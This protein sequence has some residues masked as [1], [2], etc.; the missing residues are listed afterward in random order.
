MAFEAKEAA[1][2]SKVELTYAA[3]NNDENAANEDLQ[4]A[5]ALT[6][7]SVVLNIAEASLSVDINSE[8]FTGNATVAY[9]DDYTFS[10]AENGEYYNYTNI[11]ANM[12]GTEVDVLDN[13][14]GTYTVENV[15]GELVI[16]AERTPK[17]FN[18]TF[19]GTGGTDASAVEG[20]AAS[21]TYLTDY[22]FTMPADTDELTYALES[23][24]IN[25]AA[26]TDCNSENGVYTIAGVDVKGNIVVNIAKTEM[27][28][29]TVRVTIEG[30]GAGVASGEA[31][32]KKGDDYTLTLNPEAG[33]LY[34]VTA[35]MGG[36]TVTVVDNENDTYTIN[37]VNGAIVFTV[38][39]SVDT[40]GVSVSA[41]PYVKVDGYVVWLVTNTTEVADG[42]VPT[43]GGEK[44]FWSEK[45]NNGQGAYC[46]LVV[47]E[48][49]TTE[50][51]QAKL[52]I[53]SGT[54]TTVDYGMD[55]N[56]T[57]KVDA[58]DAQLTYNIYNAMYNGFT[59]DVTVEK[60]LR[61]DVNA[62]AEI[63]VNDAA[64]IVT[65]ILNPTAT[66]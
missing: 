22:T 31:T 30:T 51:A 64:A 61:A 25:G 40:S 17:T 60:F 42:K 14:D 8:M 50:D 44:M 11:T 9:G 28:E 5:A 59:T 63:N 45:Y 33:Y 4:V 55:V 13:N 19:G 57:G 43:Y 35:T 47:S 34:K 18:V 6:P 27:P 52:D 1:S 24:T 49:L 10:L 58:S 7:A 2:N 46:Y 48:S 16:T 54:K 32:V 26:Y 56:M 12:G 21:A 62:D 20:N 66:N 53:A 38:A 29:D 36:E 41:E 15:T 65:Y 23:I 3:F 37:D 39:R